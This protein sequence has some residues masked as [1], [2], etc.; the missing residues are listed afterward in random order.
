M[1]SAAVISL[2]IIGSDKTAIDAAMLAKRISAVEKSVERFEV[3]GERKFASFDVQLVGNENSTMDWS[4]LS[5]I[6]RTYES[7]LS[8]TVERDFMK[9]TL[10]YSSGAKTDSWEEFHVS[11]R[12]NVL[13]H[14]NLDGPIPTVMV[15]AEPFE[16]C[17]DDGRPR[18]DL[19]WLKPIRGA[20]LSE[21]IL[22]TQDAKTK[23]LWPES[24]DHTFD[25]ERFRINS[26]KGEPGRRTVDISLVYLHTTKDKKHRV[27]LEAYRL[28]LAEEH[29]FM[30]V[31]ICPLSPRIIDE[32]RGKM[33]DGEANTVIMID[34]R[35][36]DNIPVP[37]VV[38]GYTL[39]FKGRVTTVRTEVRSVRLNANAVVREAAEIPAGA[40]VVDSI[41]G[42]T[43]RQVN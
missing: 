1:F 13:F 38:N 7:P 41:Q 26:I 28:L 4:V 36:F 30:P 37:H 35:R 27:S 14:H 11:K 31:V 34:Y 42:K 18:W 15:S 6:P 24:N 3:S 40:W 2:L 23:A 9:E 43:Y 17:R 39:P 16:R 19:Q 5:S 25:E 12:R 32:K 29:D 20:F 10:Y 22:Q 33:I 21:A 8:F